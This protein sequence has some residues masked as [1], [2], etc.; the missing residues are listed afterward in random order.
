MKV[1]YSLKR[2]FEIYRE[3]M[4]REIVTISLKTNLCYLLVQYFLCVSAMAEKA[5]E[6]ILN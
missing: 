2:K 5:L 6:L 3:E 1:K 4:S